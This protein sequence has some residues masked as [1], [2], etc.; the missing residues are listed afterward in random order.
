MVQQ[1]S[2]ARIAIVERAP[3]VAL[4]RVIV[5]MGAARLP[6]PP[7]EL[8]HLYGSIRTTC[9]VVETPAEAPTSLHYRYAVADGA[10]ALKADYGIK[11]AEV[12]GGVLAR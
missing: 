9:M 12:R 2:L 10:S 6:T 5:G 3:V 4:Q 8:A 7:Q 1:R 11:L